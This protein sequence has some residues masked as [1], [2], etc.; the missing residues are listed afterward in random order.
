[1]MRRLWDHRT[2]DP[3]Y[4]FETPTHR[5]TVTKRVT[6][7]PYRKHHPIVDPHREPR[8]SGRQGS[9]EGLAGLPRHLCRR[10]SLVEQVRIYRAALVQANHPQGVVEECLRW[11]TVDWLSVVVARI[12]MPRPMARAEEARGEHL[13]MRSDYIARL[14]PVEGPAI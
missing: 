2:G 10:M 5:G 3:D 1:M 11:C 12:P 8:C 7:A 14:R 6:P 13:A 4:V 9:A